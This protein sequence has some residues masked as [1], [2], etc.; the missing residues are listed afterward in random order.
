MAASSKFLI[1]ITLLSALGSH[2][3]WPAGSALVA[4]RQVTVALL[5]LS[6]PFAGT[7]HTEVSHPGA[8]FPHNWASLM[9]VIVLVLWLAGFA[10]VLMGCVIRWRR[11]AAALRTAERLEAGRE[12][13]A[14]LP[15]RK[16]MGI[17]SDVPVRLSESSFEPGV[18]GI[19][20]PV[21]MLPT[22]IS[23]RLP[24]SQLEAIAAHELCHVARRDNLTAVVHMAVEAIFWFHPLVWWIG[25]RLVE[26]RERA[27]DE[28]VVSFGG[29]PEIYAEAILNVCKFYMQSPLVC[30]AGVTGSNLRKRIEEIMAHRIADKLN[31]RKKLMLSVAGVAVAIGP[32]LIGILNAPE[33]KAQPQSEHLAFEVASVK[34]NNSIGFQDSKPPGFLPG[35][36][37]LARNMP[38]AVIVSAAYNIP[39]QSPR[40]TGGPDWKL[41]A[42]GKYDIEATAEKGAIPPGSTTRVRD[43]KLRL[44][45]QSLLEERFKLKVRRESKEEPVYA[46]VVAK[47]GPKLQKSKM[48]EKDCADGPTGL[49]VGC[50]S[51]GG[52][53]GRG[54]HGDA[55]DIADVAL[56]VQNWTDRPVVDKTGLTDLYNIQTDGWMPMR[57]R[58]PSPE[59]AP[60]GNDPDLNDPDRKTLYKVFG[61]LG[62]RV[63]SQRAMVDTFVVEHVEKPGEN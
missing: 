34:P 56:F 42:S 50:H 7:A 20:R 14:L 61:Q 38:L 37:F 11:I 46:L 63:E 2:I 9:L 18:F 36:R 16:A 24:G 49:G 21:L 39:F 55:V 40:L 13:E 15:V 54:L 62:L 47:G 48:Q 28:A 25:S 45:L 57:P 51:L 59:G 19:L 33:V 3:P 53:Q 60:K 30:V 29:D 31:F 22:R 10:M 41:L 35:G 26:E 5:G 23:E 1:P 52:G 4:P 27:C 8:G 43:D 44:M 12:N 32:I 58:P 17:R 6:Q